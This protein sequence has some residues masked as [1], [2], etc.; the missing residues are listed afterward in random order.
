MRDDFEASGKRQRLINELRQ[1]GIADDN[2]LEAMSKIPRH[3]FI[4]TI[5]LSH[6]YV[7]KAFPIDSGQTIS[8]PSTVAIQTTLLKVKE[9]NKILEIGTGSGYQSAV[10]AEMGAK[11]YTIERQKSLYEKAKKT[12][13]AL[14]YKTIQFFYGDGYKGK[15]LYGPFD[16]III[17]AAIKEIPQ[18][19]IDQLKV[20]GRLVAPIGQGDSQTM[21]CMEKQED[22]SCISKTYGDCAFVPMLSGIK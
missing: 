7:D 22:G 2:V 10:L 19:L 3:L 11:V 14:G 1:K 8:Q 16:G 17:T 6:A 18:T 12:L 20:G 21:T 13:T 4:D 5:F 15:P 9:W